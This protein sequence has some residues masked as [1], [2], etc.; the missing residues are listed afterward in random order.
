MT[1][2]L[3]KSIMRRVY[4]IWFARQVF[5]AL[6]IKAAL[7]ALLAW[8]LMSYVSVKNV[9]ANWHFDG[10]LAAS[11]AF[12]R[13]ALVET[14]FVTQMLLLSIVAVALLFARDIVQRRRFSHYRKAF[15]RA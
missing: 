4:V 6:T 1:Y 13:S 5:N 11:Y 14:E 9:I 2:D 7:V 3:T 8:R 12:F 15:V 10:S